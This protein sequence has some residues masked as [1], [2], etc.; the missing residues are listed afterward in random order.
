M[1]KKAKMVVTT[2]VIAI[3]LVLVLLPVLMEK[4]ILQ[5]EVKSVISN[6][7]W[8]GFLGSY[9]GGI[10]GGLCT[11]AAIYFSTKGLKV[12]IIEGLP[13]L[14]LEYEEI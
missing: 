7:S 5:S 8:A 6:D 11:L 4:F 12:S 3:F 1:S 10:V 2:T 13:L 14:S 9:V